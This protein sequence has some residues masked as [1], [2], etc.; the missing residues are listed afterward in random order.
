MGLAI[1]AR[2]VALRNHVAFVRG[3]PPVV[4]WT[5]GGRTVG[6]CFNADRSTDRPAGQ[7]AG[8]AGA[9]SGI[10]DDAFERGSYE[11]PM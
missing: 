3:P 6:G 9:G 2:P 1:A 11:L 7:P 5:A 4:T 8:R 10:L